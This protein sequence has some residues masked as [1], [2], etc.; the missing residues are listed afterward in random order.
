LEALY[1]PGR[2]T[3]WADGV[4]AYFDAKKR[5][6]R[7]QLRATNPKLYAIIDE[8]FAYSEHPDWRFS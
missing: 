2:A 8:V 1:G 6:S 5:G 3:R 7:E 4:E